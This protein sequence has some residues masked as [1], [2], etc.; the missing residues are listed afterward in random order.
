ME[1]QTMEQA[2][3][4]VSGSEVT[5]QRPIEQMPQCPRKQ[6]AKSRRNKKFQLKKK[7]EK[8]GVNS[9]TADLILKSMKTEDVSLRGL[10]SSFFNEILAFITE[11]VQREENLIRTNLLTENVDPLIIEG[12]LNKT[13]DKESI[14]RVIDVASLPS[15][16]FSM[17]LRNCSLR[18]EIKKTKDV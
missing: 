15:D 8:Y 4:D 18:I 2:V 13:I 16:G 3:I 14:Q 12:V 11:N 6:N 10:P 17:V 9:E 5:Q 1:H 7:L